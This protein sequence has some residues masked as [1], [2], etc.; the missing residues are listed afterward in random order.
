MTGDG[1]TDNNP[2][3]ATDVD[4]LVSGIPA[5]TVC[6]VHE[7]TEAGFASQPD[8]QVTILANQTV[9]VTFTGTPGGP[10]GQ[11]GQ[12]GPDVLFEHQGGDFL[13]GGL[14]VHGHGVGSHDLAKRRHGGTL[15]RRTAESG[16]SQL[17]GPREEEKARGPLPSADC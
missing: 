12:H 5:G 4:D 11:A 6:T 1:N 3:T 10:V 9:N 17:K 8:R 15:L 13:E 2:A 7:F 14:R 16:G